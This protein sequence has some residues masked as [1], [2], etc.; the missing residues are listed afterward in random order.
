M[1]FPK[2]IFS[3]I[4][5]S[6]Q[7]IDHLLILDNKERKTPEDRKTIIREHNQLLKQY[8]MLI[9]LFRLYDEDF[10]INDE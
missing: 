8:E 10:Y 2:E 5:F 6:K 4:M 9:V 1:D 3:N 7:I